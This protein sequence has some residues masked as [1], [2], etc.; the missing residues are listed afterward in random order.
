MVWMTEE[1]PVSWWMCEGVERRYGEWKGK[2]D[3][4][5]MVW[6]AEMIRKRKSP[7]PS[8]PAAGRPTVRLYT[9]LT[10][11]PFHRCVPPLSP[12]SF[13]SV[14]FISHQPS[15]SL[16]FHSLSFILSSVLFLH[17]NF[18]HILVSSPFSTSLAIHPFCFFYSF[19][20]PSFF[21]LSRPFLLP[22]FAPLLTFPI[23][24]FLCFIFPTA[25]FFLFLFIPPC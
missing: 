15:L 9:L 13:F 11:L 24:F 8:L 19:P 22:S 3:A 2:V 4:E 18:L 23:A 20:L 17:Y 25:L 14:L 6:V 12:L 10:C 21:S 16:L 7:L 5:W 1:L